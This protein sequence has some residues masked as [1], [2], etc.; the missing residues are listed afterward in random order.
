MRPRWRPARLPRAALQLFDAWP[1]DP[2]ALVQDQFYDQ[3]H[4]IREMRLF[5]GRTPARLGAS[6][7]PMLSALLDLRNFRE[8]TPRVAVIPGEFDPRI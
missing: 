5:A 1:A 8:I 7:Q 4:M 6:D 2:V 3:S